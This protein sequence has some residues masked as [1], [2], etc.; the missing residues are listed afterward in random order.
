MK[1]KIAFVLV[2]IV[3]VVTIFTGLARAQPTFGFVNITNNNA[4]DAAIGEAQLFVEVSDPGGGLVLFDFFNAGPADSSIAD[5]YFDDGDLLSLVSIDNSDPGVSFS[6]GASPPNL[7]GANNA[8]PP[9]VTTAGL[10]ADS[11][12]PVQPNGVNPGESVGLTFSLAGMQT[13]DDVIDDLTSAD[14]RIGIPVQGFASGGSES[15]VNGPMTNGNGN[16]NGIIPAPGALVL[17][18]IG[19]IFVGWLRR[20]RTL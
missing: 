16:G 15:F 11:D 20:R 3:L 4:G 17:S 13:F 5:I 14:L 9:F 18:S 1:K 7:P 19:I 2:F 8:S 6:Q 10:L 12:P